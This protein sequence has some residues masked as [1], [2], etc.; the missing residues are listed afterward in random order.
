MTTKILN[1][2]GFAQLAE[3]PELPVTDGFC[4]DLLSWVMGRAQEGQVWFTVMGNVNTVA[5]ATLTGLSAIVLCNGAEPDSEMLAKAGEQ[6]VN[7]YKTGL[8]EYQAAVLYAQQLEK[9]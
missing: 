2:L 1:E 6:A 3:G 8:T 9:E 4:G 5:V 7:V